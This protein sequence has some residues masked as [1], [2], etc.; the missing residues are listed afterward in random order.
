[1]AKQRK[2]GTPKKRRKGYGGPGSQ[3]P[4]GSQSSGGAMQNMVGG[5]RRAVGV[6]KPKQTGGLGRYF[7]P[8]LLLLIL[9]AVV[10][11]RFIRQ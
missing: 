4:S 6:E 9:A 11:W 5:F 2:S 1:M 3:A 7:W 8:G 10:Y